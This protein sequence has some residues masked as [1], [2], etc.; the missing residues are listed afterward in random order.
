MDV[1]KCIERMLSS[2]VAAELALPVDVKNVKP[3]AA[4][5]AFSAGKQ[6]SQ[7][8]N[9]KYLTKIREVNYE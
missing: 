5:P 2:F 9:N 8:Q 1:Y 4:K 6:A 3:T 7:L